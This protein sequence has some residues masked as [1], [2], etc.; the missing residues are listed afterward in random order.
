[1]SVVLIAHPNPIERNYRAAIDRLDRLVA[2]SWNQDKTIA[3][4]DLLEA[5]IAIDPAT[6]KPVVLL[7]SDKLSGS[8]LLEIADLVKGEAVA[9]IITEQV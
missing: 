8:A 9:S 3:T 6:L 1:M 4:G 2:L 5:E 7:H